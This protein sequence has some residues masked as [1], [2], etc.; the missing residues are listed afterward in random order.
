[1]T[2]DAVYIWRLEYWISMNGKISISLVI[3]DYQENVGLA[4]GNGG[5]SQENGKHTT[6]L[7]NNSKHRYS[8]AL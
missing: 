1:M 7:I 8:L 6:E 3:R 2:A 5:N 4:G